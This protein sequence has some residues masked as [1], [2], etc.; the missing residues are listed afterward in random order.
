MLSSF[1]NLFFAGSIIKKDSNKTENVYNLIDKN[2]IIFSENATAYSLSNGKYSNLM[3]ES[4]GLIL[5]ETL[6][7][8]SENIAI[9]F[10]SLL[11]IDVIDKEDNIG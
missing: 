10:E 1:N 6:D 7:R 5:A 2:E 4:D 9:Q 8:V 11:D 3:D